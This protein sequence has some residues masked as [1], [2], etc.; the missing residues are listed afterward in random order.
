MP[1]STNTE[2]VNAIQ[3]LSQHSATALYEITGSIYN[4]QESETLEL[5]LTKYLL[6]AASQIMINNYNRFAD[7]R[8][9]FYLSK[10][11]VEDE[12]VEYE[13]NIPSDAEA[14]N[15]EDEDEDDNDES[16]DLEDTRAA[17]EAES[18]EDFVDEE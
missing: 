5:G 15:C 18:D 3:G 9:L 6:E 11:N 12:I 16:E 7:G 1:S 2:L 13:R 14:D 8:S 17:D 10:S 4:A